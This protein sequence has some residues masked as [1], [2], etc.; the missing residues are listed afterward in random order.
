MK[1]GENVRKYRKEAGLTQKDLAKKLSV[2]PAAVSQFE[3]AESLNYSTIVKIANALNIDPYYLING[4]GSYKRPDVFVPQETIDKMVKNLALTARQAEAALLSQ[5]DFDA[6][7]HF[8]PLNDTNKD[9]ALDYM[10]LLKF[11]QDA[12]PD[13]NK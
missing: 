6:L 3:N 1:L 4:D 10:E 12:D 5:S 9:K 2:S 11:R 8:R 7:D 13:K